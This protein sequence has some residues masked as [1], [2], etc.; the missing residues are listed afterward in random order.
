MKS[1]KRLVLEAVTAPLIM[2][3]FMWVLFYIRPPHDISRENFNTSW[4]MI[5]AVSYLITLVIVVIFV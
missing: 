4:L 5:T 3:V 1:G 2:W